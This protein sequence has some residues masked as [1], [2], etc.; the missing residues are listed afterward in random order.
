MNP[1][2]WTKVI[3]VDPMQFNNDVNALT[4][5]FWNILD[6]SINQSG[7]LVAIFSRKVQERIP[8][9]PEEPEVFTFNRRVR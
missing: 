5:Q 1:Y 7:M 2:E 3:E 8:V 4:R 9:P 6:I